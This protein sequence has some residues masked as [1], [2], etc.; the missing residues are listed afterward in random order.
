MNHESAEALVWTA[1]IVIM[2]ALVVISPSGGFALL[3]LA[4]ICAAI[5]AVFAAKKTRIIAIVL[6]IAAIAL[7]ASIYPAFKQD[8]S[9][10]LQHA[11]AKAGY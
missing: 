6:L 5:P 7:A 3:I 11:R 10:Y 2:F 1:G 9:G 4:A 8:Y